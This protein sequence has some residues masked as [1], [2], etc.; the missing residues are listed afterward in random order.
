M[1]LKVITGEIDL[2]LF[3]FTILHITETKSKP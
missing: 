3:Q 1:K 2:L